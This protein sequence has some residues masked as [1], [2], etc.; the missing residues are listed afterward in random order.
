MVSNHAKGERQITELSTHR[1]LNQGGLYRISGL[2]SNSPHP[3][4]GCLQKVSWFESLYNFRVQNLLPGEE[5]P[6]P[7]HL[8]G[9]C[10][11]RVGCC[12]EKANFAYSLLWLGKTNERGVRPMSPLVE[13]I[14]GHYQR[15]WFNASTAPYLPNP[16]FLYHLEQMQ[17]SPQTLARDVK[18]FLGLDGDLSP[19]PHRKPGLEIVDEDLRQQKERLKIDICDPAYRGVRSDLTRIGSLGAQWL[20][21]ELLPLSSTIHMSDPAGFQKILHRWSRDPCGN[22]SKT[23][24]VPLQ[25]PPKNDPIIHG[26][27]PFKVHVSGQG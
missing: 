12:T 23:Q 15:L 16:V 7:N 21:Q 9:R 18:K 6:D 11:H 26:M 17:E 25:R 1:A 3:M 14:V 27:L 5:M 4:Y 20:E 13:K 22:S 19:W 2:W 8:I 24:R 10:Y